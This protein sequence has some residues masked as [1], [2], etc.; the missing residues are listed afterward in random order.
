MNDSLSRGVMLERNG[1]QTTF[2]V[3]PWRT[4]PR[5]LCCHLQTKASNC[6]RMAHSFPAG[7][8]AGPDIQESV[9]KLVKKASSWGPLPDI[10]VQEVSGGTWKSIVQQRFSGGFMQGFRGPHV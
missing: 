8:S 5:S 1:P 3:D 10:L 6:L 9:R 7:P 2:D 4:G